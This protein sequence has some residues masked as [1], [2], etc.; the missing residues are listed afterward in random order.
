[1]FKE[2]DVK[3]FVTSLSCKKLPQKLEVMGSMNDDLQRLM[4][5]RLMG[6]FLGLLFWFSRR[7]A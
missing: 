5:R 4:R 2:F 3:H 6:L 1:M 7:S